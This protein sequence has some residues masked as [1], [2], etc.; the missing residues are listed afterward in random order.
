MV[1]ENHFLVDLLTGLL[2]E[3]IGPNCLYNISAKKIIS[4]PVRKERITIEGLK[5]ANGPVLFK[6]IMLIALN[7]TVPKPP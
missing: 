1:L 5:K 2:I 4:A 7:T 6:D 3:N